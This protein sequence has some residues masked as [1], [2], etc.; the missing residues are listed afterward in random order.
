MKKRKKLTVFYGWVVRVNELVL[1]K[2]N[3]QRRL[4]CKRNFRFITE[5]PGWG[6]WKN[7]TLQQYPC[8]IHARFSKCMCRGGPGSPLLLPLEGN[9]L[10]ISCW[11]VAGSYLPWRVHIQHSCICY[12]ANVATKGCVPLPHWTTPFA[13][14]LA[15]S[16]VGSG[17]E[18]RAEW[19][20]L[21]SVLPFVTDV[22]CQTIWSANPS[23]DVP[24]QHIQV[25]MSTW[26]SHCKSTHEKNLM[27]CAQFITLAAPKTC[28]PTVNRK[29]LGLKCSGSW[30]LAALLEGRGRELIKNSTHNKLKNFTCCC[31]FT[32]TENGEAWLSIFTHQHSGI[33]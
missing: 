7:S 28:I 11:T 27:I 17:E 23:R 30:I 24:Q 33:P 1:N 29:L 21:R 12:Q 6:G 9:E 16:Q 31:S 10:Q 15:T 3:R 19:A 4:P 13:S 8:F 5:V 2:L 26:L 14:H 20:D 32:K 25:H 18:T 22:P